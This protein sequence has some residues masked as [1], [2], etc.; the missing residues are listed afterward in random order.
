MIKKVDLL[1]CCVLVFFLIFP[2]SRSVGQVSFGMSAGGGITQSTGIR[3]ALPLELELGTNVY[4][5]GGPAFLQRRNPE[6]I[7]KLHPMRDYFT[8]ETDYVSLPLAI[9][10]RLDWTPLRIYGMVGIEVNYGLRMQATGVEDQRLFKE[11]LDFHRDGIRQL[12]GGAF[13]GAG[14]ETDLRRE[15]KIFAD[16]R[17]YLGMFDIDKAPDG[18]I[19]NAGSYLTLGLLLPVAGDH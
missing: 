9:K 13:A 3:F 17:Y 19:Y 14:F 10:I 4:L 1:L 18:E 6:I 16:L 12:E 2:F 11:K 15:R 7:R 5:F 8:V